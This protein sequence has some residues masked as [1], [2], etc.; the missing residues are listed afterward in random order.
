M[1]YG[2]DLFLF[3]M[4]DIDKILCSDVSD[5]ATPPPPHSRRFW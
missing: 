3:D 5:S 4:K 2:C 1:L